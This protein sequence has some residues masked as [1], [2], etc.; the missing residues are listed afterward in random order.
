MCGHKG[1]TSTAKWARS[2]PDIVQALGFTHEKSPCS[3]TMRI[4]LKILDSDAVEKTFTNWVSLITE[5]LQN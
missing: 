5:S 1:Y 2:Q 4:V 3:A